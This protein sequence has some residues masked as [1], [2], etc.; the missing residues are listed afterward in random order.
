MIEMKIPG[1]FTNKAYS[2]YEDK[3]ET[4]VL[5]GNI[6]EHIAIIMDGNRRYAAEV[7]KADEKEGHI[8][9]KDKLEEVLE[10]CYKVKVKTLSVYAFS[11]ENFSREEEEVSFLFD[12]MEE[13]IMHFADDEKTH[14]NRVRLRII[15]EKDLFPDGFKNAVA[16]AEE[17]TKDYSDFSLNIAVAYGG[18]QEIVKAVK[19]IAKDVLD[20]KM[21]VKDIDELAISRHMYTYEMPDPD[22]MLRTSGELRISNFLLWQMAYSEL[23]FADVYWP[24]FRYIDFLRAIRSYQQRKR[25]YGK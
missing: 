8:K 17:R 22:L 15:G 4:E 3:L 25:R 18:R 9:G 12:L 5:Q 6:P 10:W 24:G 21:D 13:T 23:Y 1:I 7:L 20:G 19:E 11:T 16:Y 2:K 14:K